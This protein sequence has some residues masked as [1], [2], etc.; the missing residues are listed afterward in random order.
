MRFHL[1]AHSSLRSQTQTLWL[2]FKSNKAALTLFPLNMSGNTWANF[3]FLYECELLP[4]CYSEQNTVCLT[5]AQYAQE[6]K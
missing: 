6:I 3:S 2:D 1:F 4:F 5:T